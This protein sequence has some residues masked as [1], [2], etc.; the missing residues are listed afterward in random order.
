M[1]NSTNKVTFGTNDIGDTHWVN[2]HLNNN[3]YSLT[4]NNKNIMYRWFNG[5]EWGTIWTK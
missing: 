2:L 1:F 3:I 4:F 5:T